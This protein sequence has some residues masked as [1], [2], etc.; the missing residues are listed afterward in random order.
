MTDHGLTEYQKASQVLESM[1][2]LAPRKSN[3]GFEQ[4]E[5]QTQPQTYLPQLGINNT[6]SPRHRNNFC[7]IHN[8]SDEKF[9]I[10]DADSSKRSRM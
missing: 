6:S 9:L 5:E 7:P 4:E 2:V 1:K 8:N 3:G 10:D